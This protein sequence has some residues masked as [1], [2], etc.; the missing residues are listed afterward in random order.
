MAHHDASV[1]PATKYTIQRN[2]TLAADLGLVPSNCSASELEAAAQHCI[3]P[4]EKLELRDGEGRVIWIVAAFDFLKAKAVPDT[5]NPSLWLNGKGNRLAGVFEIVPHNIYQV[6]GFDI[7]NLSIV[8]SDHGWIVQD[9]M[10]SVE[11][12]RA[13]LQLLQEALGEPV[14]NKIT[15]V[16]ISH[17]HGDHF[18]GI[19]G[20]VTPEQVGKASDGKIPIYVPAGFDEEAV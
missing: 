7:S 11:T 8:R 16:I 13:A 1:K 14:V 15:A 6:R 17:S 10:M 20:V 5:V 12:S 19:R 9:A 2:R 4:V 3:Y 18:G